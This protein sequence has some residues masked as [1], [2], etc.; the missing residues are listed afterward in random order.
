MEYN[1]KYVGESSRTFHER[2][3]EHPKGPTS[4]HCHQFTTGHPTILDNFSIVS[5]E[6]KGFPRAIKD[7]GFLMVNDSTPNRN[8]GKYNLPNIL[9]GVLKTPLNSNQ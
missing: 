1:D 5:R 3:K 2:V 7:S 9:D 6:G 8:N 4:I